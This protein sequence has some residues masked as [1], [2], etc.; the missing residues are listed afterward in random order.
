MKRILLLL[1]I[2]IKTTP[3]IAQLKLTDYN[4]AKNFLWANVSKKIQNYYINPIWIETGDGFIYETT[5]INNEKEFT[6]VDFIQKSPTTYITQ[7]QLAKHFKPDF[8]L[9]KISNVKVA[10]LGEIAFDYENKTYNYAIA[11]DKFLTTDTVNIKQISETE[12]TSPD[13]N[14]I[15]YNKDYNLYIK[16]TKDGAVRQITFDGKRFYEYGTYYGWSD[17]IEGENG[18][19]PERLSIEW[20]P[21][22]KWLQ[23]YVTDLRVAEKMYLLDWSIDTLYKP[24]LLSYYRASPGDTNIVKMTPLFVEVNTGKTILKKEMVSTHTN[25]PIYNWLKESGQLIQHKLYRGYQKLTLHKVDLNKQKDELI[26]EEKSKTNIDNFEHYVLEDKNMI[27]IL[28]EKDGWRQLYKIA[29]E[30]YKVTPITKGEYYINTIFEDKISDDNLYF[31]A[32]GKEENENPYHQYL[33]KI[34]LQNSKQELITKSKGN[35]EISFSKNLQWIIDNTSSLTTEPKISLVNL[36]NSKEQ[37]QLSKPNLYYLK[38]SLQY[39][40]AEVFTAIGRDNKTIIYGAMW[41]PTDFNPSKKY[42]VIDQTYTG[43]HTFMFPRTYTGSLARNNQALAELGFIVIAVDGM[44]TANR[45]K[46]FQNVSYKNMG[47]NLEDHVL[48]IQQLGRKYNF[49]DTNKVGIFGHSAGGYDAGHAML[50]Y[51]NFYKVAVASS[52]DHDFR[53]EKAWWP[54]MY[55]GWPVDSTYHQVSN[56]TIANN[57]KGKLLM[58][59]GGIDENVNPSATFKLAEAFIKAD[60]EFDLL[61][62]PSMRHGYTGKYNNYFNKKKWNYFVEHLKNETP[63]WDFQLD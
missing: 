36:I 16:S 3:I 59:H 61:I 4:R 30:D 33:Y 14:W 2:S 8:T 29:L 25:P 38:D 40:G 10:K 35:H 23:T 39:K 7:Q 62:I 13:G 21:D 52:A 28:S 26:Y 9:S 32:S 6:I 44:G 63:I 20:S 51:P 58:V 56:I 60:K 53:M 34:N 41:K 47:K 17:I 18:Q 5:T 22:S 46:A 15:A 48:A 50:A 24:K 49:I 55:M 12:S 1:L 37:T 54:E 45:S 43:P 19:R 42:P 57:L 11:T 27:L 31:T